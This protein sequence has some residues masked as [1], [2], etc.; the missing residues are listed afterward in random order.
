MTW[1]HHSQTDPMT[2][3]VGWVSD[4]CAPLSTRIQ[5]ESMLVLRG[6]AGVGLERVRARVRVRVNCNVLDMRGVR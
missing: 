4:E 1:W 3:S 5:K 6:A 2:C